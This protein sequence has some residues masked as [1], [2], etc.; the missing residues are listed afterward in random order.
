MNENWFFM[1]SMIYALI[2]FPISLI[3][4][5]QIMRFNLSATPTERCSHDAPTPT[6]GGLGFSLIFIGFLSYLLFTEESLKLPLVYNY[7][8]AACLLLIVSLYDDCKPLSYRLRLAT[9]LVCALLLVMGDGIIESPVIDIQSDSVLL[10]QKIL[11]VFTFLSLI[12]AT[13]FID[14]LNGLLSLCIMITLGFAG[15]WIHD[16]QVLNHMHWVLIG[17]VLGFFILNFPNGKIFMGDTG[18]TF[19][20]LTLGFFALLA[21]SHYPASVHHETAIFNKGFVFTLL[22]MAFLW[23]DVIFTLLRRIV[24]GEHLAQAHRDHMIHILFDKGY[25]HVFVT[26][27]YASGTVLMGSLTYLCHAERISFIML[28]GIYA[29]LQTMFVMFTFKVPQRQSK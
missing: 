29:V 2:S 24:R 28:L 21:Q 18:S 15:L 26:L 1:T 12:N 14:G 16:Y 4:C 9:Q 17:A 7:L 20:G 23:F 3:L 13:N 10:F 22:P 6:A 27:L 25:K 19:L 8:S 11:T 5:S